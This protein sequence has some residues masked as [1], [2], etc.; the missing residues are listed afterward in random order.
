MMN[1]LEKLKNLIEKQY[2]TVLSADLD[3]YEIPRTYLHMMVA[4]GKLERVERGVYVSTDS[5]VDEMY[6]M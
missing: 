1:H 4:E 6:A 2:G 3:L 5:I